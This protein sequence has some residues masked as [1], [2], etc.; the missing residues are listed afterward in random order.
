M[1]GAGFVAVIACAQALVVPQRVSIRK[2]TRRRAEDEDVE[3]LREKAAQLREEV[4][5]LQAEALAERGEEEKPIVPP[6]PKPKPVPKPE[7]VRRPQEDEVPLA[8]RALACLP[9]VLPLCDALP[10]GK[11]VITEFP[12]LALALLPLAP[13][14]PLMA[15]VNAV[16]FGEFILFIVLT[17][18]SR[19]PSFSRFVRF[20][21]QQAVLL[22]I[23]LI[24][25]QLLG[26][27]G[28]ALKLS[29]P[30]SI[31][32]PLSTTVFFAVLASVC[33][34]LVANGFGN[35]PNGIPVVSEATERS[36]GPF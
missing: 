23:A 10:F 22:D 18:S 29:P 14:A 13:F 27:V 3:A 21:M 16:P 11:Y 2:K 31:V 4:A 33:Y 7:P 19:N 9:Y 32:E 6:P 12:A 25:P 34:S 35:T 24:F 36:L 20:S 17:T 30:E 8:E 1:R 15:I 26:Q 5:L 28:S